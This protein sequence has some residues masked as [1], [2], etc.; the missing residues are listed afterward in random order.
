MNLEVLE[1]RKTP[2]Y[3]YDLKRLEENLNALTEASSS[4]GYEVH[5]AV[6]ANANPR[7]M[8]LIQ[9]KGFGAD[10]VSGGEV[11]RALDCGFAPEKIVFAGVGKSDEEILLGLRNNIFV[12][13]CE[14]S[15][16]VE[17]LE[18]LAKQEGKAARLALRIKPNVDARTHHY[19]TT[20]LEENKFGID[21]SDLPN[22]MDRIQSSEYLDFQGIH[23]HIGS[24]I[25][26]M[27]VFKNLCTKVNRVLEWFREQKI[28][29]QHLNLGGG[30]GVDYAK[31]DEDKPNY[32]EFFQI[33]QDHLELQG[34]QVHFE[35]GRVVTAHCGSLICKVLYTKRGINT[36][37]L[38]LD[39]GMTELIRPA[40]YQSYHRIENWNK[41]GSDEKETYDVVGPICES[42]DYFGKSVQLPL[43]ERGDFVAVRSC[44]AY[45]E[46]MASH[47]NLR[48][49]GEDLFI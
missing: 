37:F 31:P 28:G 6:K 11:Q 21:F 23:F 3:L 27:S 38:I 14:S 34:E 30:L 18:E 5:Y 7:I 8:K 4:F 47:Y 44:G 1:N 19:I 10:C 22:I 24:Q 13:N 36:N 33:F 49:R 25:T 2:F 17:V 20:G 29:I 41:N 32:R 15:Q 40:L 43:S 35:L 42:S 12:F 46:V 39:G 48:E 26:E 9:E 16:E 45:G